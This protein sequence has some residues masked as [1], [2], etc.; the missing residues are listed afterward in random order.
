MYI[1]DIV[2]KRKKN[3]RK[4]EVDE[5]ETNSVMLVPYIYIFFFSQNLCDDC[6]M[7]WRENASIPPPY[8]FKM[9]FF[10]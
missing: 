4:E 7:V 5:G 3:N 8:E 6:A 2:R 1:N 9:A 10:A